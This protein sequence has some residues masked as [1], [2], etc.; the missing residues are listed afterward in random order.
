[1]VRAPVNGLVLGAAL[2]AFSHGAPAT[3]RAAQIDPCSLIP[4]A[5]AA[6]MTGGTGKG[7]RHRTLGRYAQETCNYDGPLKRA[8]LVAV[9]LDAAPFAAAKSMIWQAAM[10]ILRQQS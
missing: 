4:T 3:V 9:H 1:M 5:Q 7:T 2:G 10:S 6:A 8:V